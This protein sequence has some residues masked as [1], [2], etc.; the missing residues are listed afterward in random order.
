MLFI[1]SLARPSSL[2]RTQ[3]PRARTQTTTIIQGYGL[4]ETCAATF[5]SQFTDAAQTGTVGPPL[6]GVELRLESVPEMG[7][8]ALNA[9]APAGEVTVRGA[10]LFAGYYKDAAKTAE[11]M[12]GDGFFKTGDIGALT[13][14]GA[15]RIVD[16]KKNIFKLSQG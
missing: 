8:D 13:P 10:I 11:E 12:T 16:R 4:T 14:S 9:A 1:F 2:T 3:T 6:P 5:I 7:Y 15:L